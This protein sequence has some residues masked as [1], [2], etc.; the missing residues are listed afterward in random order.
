MDKSDC[1]F[2]GVV[3]CPEFLVHFPTLSKLAD[4]RFGLLMVAKRRFANYFSQFSQSGMGLLGK[5]NALV[6]QYVSFP[7]R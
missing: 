2:Q 3:D 7:T 4:K 6:W 1:L 5:M